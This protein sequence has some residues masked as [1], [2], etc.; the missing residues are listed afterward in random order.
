MRSRRILIVTY[1][2][3]PRASI[4]SA[5]WAAMSDWLR[6]LGHEVTVLT[7]RFGDAAETDAPHVLR[8]LDLGGVGSLRMLLRRG[9]VQ[10]GAAATLVRKPTPRW[11]TNVIVPDE[12]LF[13][14]GPATLLA[15]ARLT[16]ERRIECVITTGP[17][18]STHL[19]PLLLGPRRPAWIVDLRDGWRFESMRASWPTQAQDR[20]DAALERLVFRSAERVM[21]VTRPIA[22]DAQERLAARSAHVPNGWDPGLGTASVPLSAR[23]AKAID[24]ERVNVVHT[25]TLSGGRGRDPR[26]VFEALRRLAAARPMV[27]ARLRLVLAGSLSIEDERLLSEVDLGVPV[28]HLGSLRREDAI[29]LQHR[30][31]VLLLL[32]SPTHVSEATGKLFEY[33]AAG[34]PILALAGDNEAA[35]IV[36]ET[37]TGVTVHPEDVDGIAS[38]LETAVDG[39]LA[40]SYVPSGLTRY[41]YPQPAEEV[42]ELAE[43]AIAQ[44]GVA[45]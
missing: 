41:V 37:H 34:R 29:E 8:T 35:R 12:C 36:A 26:P 30:A 39:R 28:E 33:L 22:V 16:K 24:S 32:T 13:T 14:W 31:D 42:A 38:A 21:G 7:T 25:G 1:Y 4:G 9:S 2:F 5:R 18:H 43:Q 27:A 23:V 6:Q 40:Q 15:M 17:P 11:F 44:R 19:L 3:P 10:Q 20:L 45:R